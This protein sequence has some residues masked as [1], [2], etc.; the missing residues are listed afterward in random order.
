MTEQASD[1]EVLDG[2]LS[3]VPAMQEIFVR[4]FSRLVFS[5]IQGVVKV[6]AAGLSQQDIEDLHNTVFVQLFE[7][8]CRKLRLYTGKNGCSLATWIRMITVRTVLDHLRLARDV[9]C[10]TECCIA[11]EE[12]VQELISEQDSPHTILEAKEQ[13]LLIEKGLQSLEP[14]DQL[15]IRLHCLD[16]Q[17][18]CR[19]ATIL[20]VTE[21]NVHSIKHRAIK[22]LK[23]ALIRHLSP[24]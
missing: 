10:R 19:I 9:M 1:K 4:R 6:K 16:E 12:L 8:R 14:R 13:Q 15:V 2:C 23:A 18:L 17:P 21:S 11:M 24:T 20:K 7:R 22:R 5:S 3:C